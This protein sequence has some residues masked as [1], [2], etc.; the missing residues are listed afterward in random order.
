MLSLGGSARGGHGPD[1]VF[2]AHMDEIGYEVTHIESDGRLQ[3]KEI[4]GFY[5]RYYLGHAMLVHTGVGRDVGGVLEPPPGWDRPDF[6][7]PPPFR[8]SGN[9]LMS[10][11]VRRARR[12]PEGSGST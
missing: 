4:G 7:W 8:T 2:D 9:P 11:S 1:L 6:K 10:M 12:K 3:V 5:D